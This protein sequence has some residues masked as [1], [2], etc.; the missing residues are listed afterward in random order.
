MLDP[1]PAV[2]FQSYPITNNQT[3][4]FTLERVER[5]EIWNASQYDSTERHA[6]EEH[7]NHIVSILS[8]DLIAAHLV[9][10]YR[11]PSRD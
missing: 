3:H 1:A 8:L 4:H 10:G 11:L 7:D 9:L 5:E 2:I 6:F